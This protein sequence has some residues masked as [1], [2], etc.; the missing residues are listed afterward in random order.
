MNGKK[1]FFFNIQNNTLEVINLMEDHKTSIKT[2]NEP[3]YIE[4]RAFI[5]VWKQILHFIC[6]DL[7]VNHLIPKR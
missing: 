4:C 7:I 2:V 6:F 3:N 1:V 5:K